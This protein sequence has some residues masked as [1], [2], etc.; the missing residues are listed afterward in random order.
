METLKY[1]IIKTEK[2]YN[3]YCNVLEDILVKGDKTLTDEIELL[4]LLIEKWDSE[5]NSFEELTPVELL[6]SLMEENNL[7]AVD[8]ARILNL[9]KGTVSKI[10]NCQKGLS[11]E[12]IRRL[13]DH[14]KLNQEAFNRP[15]KLVNQINRHFRN[16]SLMNTPKNLG[17]KQTV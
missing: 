8:L 7:K 11:K 10:L 15:Y 5:N 14:F 1:T 17:K 12:T 16:A 2:Q 6:K 3:E 13:S 4:T 9:S